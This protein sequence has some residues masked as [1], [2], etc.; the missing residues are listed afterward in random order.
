MKLLLFRIDYYKYLCAKNLREFSSL[1]W[2]NKFNTTFFICSSFSL[3]ILFCF[4]SS[5]R[6]KRKLPFA[7]PQTEHCPLDMSDPSLQ[8]EHP[9]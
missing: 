2:K 5:H 4:D 9:H 7:I 1:I 6:S 8:N 3:F